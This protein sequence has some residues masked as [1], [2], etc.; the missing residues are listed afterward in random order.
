[1]EKEKKD[2][3]TAISLVKP[4]KILIRGYDLMQLMEKVSFGDMICLMFTEKLP[5]KNEGKM[6]EAMLVCSAEHGMATPSTNVVR[7]AASCGVPLQASVAAGIISLGDYHG[8]ARL[9]TLVYFDRLRQEK[10]A[11]MPDGREKVFLDLLLVA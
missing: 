10:R 9:I 3:T 8:G 7:S 5:Q 2:L 4:G 1:M 11:V 6:I